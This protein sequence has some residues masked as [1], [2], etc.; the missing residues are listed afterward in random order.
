MLATE[1]LRQLFDNLA[2]VGEDEAGQEAEARAD[3]LLGLII[4]DRG[5]SRQFLIAMGSFVVYSFVA[6]PE[7]MNPTDAIKALTSLGDPITNFDRLLQALHRA[8]LGGQKVN[9]DAG[10]LSRQIAHRPDDA[11]IILWVLANYLVVTA[12]N[13]GDLA[14][15]IDTFIASSVRQ[16]LIQES[17]L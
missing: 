8:L 1:A 5:T 17:H 13:G 6:Q 11:A 10:R 12:R 9:R 4:D 3:E 14:G 16:G 15:F 7:V 2:A